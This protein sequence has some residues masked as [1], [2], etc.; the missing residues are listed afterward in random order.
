MEAGKV[1]HLWNLEDQGTSP[2]AHQHKLPRALA[3][4]V[5][6]A[7]AVGSG[8]HAAERQDREAIA[9][10]AK[11]VVGLWHIRGG[12]ARGRLI[13]RTKC[14]PPREKCLDGLWSFMP[15]RRHDPELDPPPQVQR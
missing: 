1:D 8:D 10:R 5:V 4:P 6:A 15:A 3:A 12:L 9:P 7:D 14:W 11:T 13:H 2:S